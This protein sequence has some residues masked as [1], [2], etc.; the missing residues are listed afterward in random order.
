MTY[1]V[2]PAPLLEQGSLQPLLTLEAVGAGVADAM[3][4]VSL[5]AQDP[6][7][8]NATTTFH[9]RVAGEAS[10]QPA[11]TGVASVLVP[12]LIAVVAVGIASWAAITV[13]RSSRREEP[14]K[15]P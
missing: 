14:P 8:L 12:T 9:V 4:E 10:S 5:T 13:R 6:V 3:L 1:A 7:G 11:D 2:L 15:A